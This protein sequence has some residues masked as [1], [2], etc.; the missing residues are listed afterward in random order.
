M[1]ELG[2]LWGLVA[3]SVTFTAASVL[4]VVLAARQRQVICPEN[5]AP[6]DVR[7]DGRQAVRSMFGRGGDRVVGCERWPE[8]AGCDRG[9]ERLIDS[10]VI[11]PARAVTGRRQA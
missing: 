2:I 5:G 10:C 6:A 11:L 3:I 9:C 8:R 7:C 4:A 1:Q